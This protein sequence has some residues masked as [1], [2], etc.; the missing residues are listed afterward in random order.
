MDCKSGGWVFVATQWQLKEG[1]GPT[2]RVLMLVT[3]T[4]KVSLLFGGVSLLE[5]V[6]L[7][8][9]EVLDVTGFP[10]SQ[11]LCSLG[12]GRSISASVVLC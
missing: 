6:V 7:T 8:R 11:W 1:E 4:V 10:A 9:M 3:R 12:V 5:G 2:A